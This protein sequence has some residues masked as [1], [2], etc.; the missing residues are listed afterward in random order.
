MISHLQ[1][2]LT[3]NRHRNQNAMGFGMTEMLVSLTAGGLIIVGAGT[4]LQS[5][6][7][8]MGT[9]GTRATLRQNTINGLKLLRN[10]ATKA[11]HLLV[12]ETFPKFHFGEIKVYEISLR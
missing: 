1:N 3:P 7:G 10:E 2:K 11:D 5:M 6:Q 9:S 8:V 4:A 12:Y